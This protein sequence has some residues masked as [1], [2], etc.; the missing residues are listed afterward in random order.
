MKLPSTLITF[1]LKARAIL[2]CCCCLQAAAQRSDLLMQFHVPWLCW[3]PRAE[4]ELQT[5]AVWTLGSTAPESQLAVGLWQC[6]T[7]WRHW[8][9]SCVS[10]AAFA[11]RR[12]PSFIWRWRWMGCFIS[13]GVALNAVAVSS[14]LWS[15]GTWKGE[16]KE[17][18]AKWSN[19]M[20]SQSF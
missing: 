18:R 7:C 8:R 15:F 12:S 17:S 4:E 13:L 2:I 11:K 6:P 19:G 20:N 10:W 1:F 14:L 3:A 9:A 16:V 5:M